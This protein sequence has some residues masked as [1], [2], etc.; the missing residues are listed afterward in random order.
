MSPAQKRALAAQQSEERGASRVEDKPAEPE[1]KK[2][3]ASVTSVATKTGP[4]EGSP[5][6]AA[7]EP[8]RRRHARGLA[9]ALFARAHDLSLPFRRFCCWAVLGRCSHDRR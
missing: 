1:E 7:A 9:P 6:P 5:K 8:V 2:P 3:E 4:A